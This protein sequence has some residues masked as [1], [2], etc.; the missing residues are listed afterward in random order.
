MS[1]LKLYFTPA[2]QLL[3]LTC[4]ILHIGRS[5][6]V[7]SVPNGP[8]TNSCAFHARLLLWNITEALAQNRLFKGFD[9]MEHNMELY[10]ETETAAAC[11]PRESTCSGVKALEFDRESCMMNIGKDLLYYSKTLE[12]HQKQSLSPAVLLSLQELMENCFPRSLSKHGQ[13]KEATLDHLNT[14]EKRVYR[15][16][17]LRGFQVRAVTINRVIEYMQSEEQEKMKHAVMQD[18]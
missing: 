1:D 9:C 2:L 13:F 18:D 17:V 16:K 6:P 8:I 10:T 12:T 15:C 3:L 11:A 14:F 5:L 7:Q 4:P